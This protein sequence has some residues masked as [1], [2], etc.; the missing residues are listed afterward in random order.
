MVS[1]R[2]ERNTVAVPVAAPLGSA[3][4]T[5]MLFASVTVIVTFV[6][7]YPEGEKPVIVHSPSRQSA[8]RDRLGV[9]DG[10]A[11]IRSSPARTGRIDTVDRRIE[12]N[13]RPANSTVLALCFTAV[14]HPRGHALQLRITSIYP[15]E[16]P[17]HLVLSRQRT[18]HPRLVNR[19]VESLCGTRHMVLHHVRATDP[20]DGQLEINRAGYLPFIH[21]VTLRGCGQFPV[22]RAIALRGIVVIS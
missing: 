9:R 14:K 11:G 19:I 22:V 3:D 6:L 17:K 13:Q 1:C 18:G 15:Q 4:A 20:V 8:C 10:A 5:V 2:P 16:T 7:L 21:R 12:H